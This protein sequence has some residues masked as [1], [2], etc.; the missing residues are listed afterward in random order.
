MESAVPP[1]AAIFFNFPSAQKPIVCPSGDQNTIAAP[2]VPWSGNGVRE[3][4]RCTQIMGPWSPLAIIATRPPDGESARD[5]RM[6]TRSSD[7]P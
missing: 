1:S 4:S 7:A 3:S 2:S 6:I 5:C